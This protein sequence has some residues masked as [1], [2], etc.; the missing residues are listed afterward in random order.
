MSAV[1]S[2]PHASR[3]QAG[4]V[5]TKATKIIR[6]VRLVRMVRVVKLYRMTGDVDELRRDDSSLEPSSVG[7]KLTERQTV[8]LISM[9]LSMILVLPWLYT[10]SLLDNAHNF[11]HDFLKHLH[12]YPQAY[13]HSGRISV[14]D[15]REQVRFYGRESYELGYPLAYL[16]VCEPQPAMVNGR[17]AGATVI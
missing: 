6:I 12:Q 17:R 10:D 13:N 5:G 15:F 16:E 3:T 4:R 7:K 11:Q 1:G 2:K 8:R 9:M 14:E